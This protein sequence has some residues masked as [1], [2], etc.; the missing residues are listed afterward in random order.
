M[1]ENIKVNEISVE[2]D[3]TL[4]SGIAQYLKEDILCPLD[5][6]TTITANKKGQETFAKA[7]KVIA[8]FGEA[9]EKEVLNI[10]NMGAAFVEYDEL[11]ARLIEDGLRYPMI[12]D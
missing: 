7:Q 4:I 10:R 1:H 8:C 11:M 5:N 12:K 9:M 6:R 3:A 2:Y